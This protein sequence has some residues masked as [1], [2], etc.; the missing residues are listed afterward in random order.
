VPER[1]EARQHDYR[2]EEN[3]RDLQALMHAGA[4]G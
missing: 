1:V 2:R 3:Q 4:Q